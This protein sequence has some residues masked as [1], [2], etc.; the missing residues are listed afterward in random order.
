MCPP[1]PEINSKLETRDSKLSMDALL[2]IHDCAALVKVRP[3]TIRD[4]VALGRFPDPTINEPRCKRWHPDRVRH[5]LQT[6]RVT[7]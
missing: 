2:T 7:P 3:R 5:F 6:G 1:K 4:W